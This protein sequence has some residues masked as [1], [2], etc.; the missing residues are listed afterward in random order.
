MEIAEHVENVGVTNANLPLALMIALGVMARQFIGVGA[1]YSTII[2]SDTTLPIAVS[3]ILSGLTFSLGLILVVLA[4]A[5]LFTGNN[6]LV[7]AWVAGGIPRPMFTRNL[8]IVFL[9]NLVGAAGLTIPVKLSGIWKKGRQ[10]SRNDGGFH[11]SS[12]MLHTV[13]RGIHLRAFSATCFFASQCREPSQAATS[14]TASSPF[15]FPSPH[16]SQQGANTV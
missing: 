16:L 5:E 13:R 10:S 12:Q 1:I 2:A 14:R 7:I 11:C 3:G 4:G 6:L 15:S 9:A 8:C